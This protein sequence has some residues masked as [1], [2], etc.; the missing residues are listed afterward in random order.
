MA[1]FFSIKED[2]IYNYH[3]VRV[4]PDTTLRTRACICVAAAPKPINSDL[5]DETSPKQDE[6]LHAPGVVGH[7]QH[8]QRLRRAMPNST[9]MNR[10]TEA[11][12]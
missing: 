5:N 6:L 10:N 7:L 4:W 11:W 1:F 8:H 9:M 2:I 12:R 3:Y